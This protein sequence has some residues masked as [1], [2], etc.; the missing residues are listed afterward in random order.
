M[1]RSKGLGRV[2]V[3]G[4]SFAGLLTAA[5]LADHADHV[6]IVDRD[7]IP[8]DP[9]QRPGVPQGRH[10]HVLLAAGRRCVE[11]LLPGIMAEFDELGVPAVGTPGDVVQLHRGRWVRRAGKSV[12]FLTGTRPLL[13][14]VVRRRVLANPRIDTM[15]GIEAVGFMGDRGRVRGLLIRRR[16]DG[17]R[18]EPEEM[19]ADLLV[20]ASGRS[21]H[22]PEWLTAIGAK[23]PAEERIDSGLCYTTR[24]YRG[25]VHPGYKGIYLIPYPESPRG[26]VVMPIEEKGRFLVTL[27][28]VVGDEPP[29]DPRGYELFSK[30]LQH[31]LVHD[32]IMAA[33]PEGPPMGFRGT[34][35]V[36]RRYDRL[37][38]RPRGLLVVGDAACS[39]NPVYG[40]GITVAAGAA[41][42]LRKALAQGVRS[43]KSLQRLVVKSAAQ[44]WT[45]SGGAD[46]KMPRATG[47]AVKDGP[48]DRFADWY[49]ARVEARSTG[50]LAVG[51]P[52]RDVLHLNA[53]AT[54]LFSWPVMR[55]VLFGRIPPTPTEPPL[56]PEPP[57]DTYG[58]PGPA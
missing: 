8:D 13:E 10:I 47:N 11:E 24:M 23:P 48:A 57:E 6:T 40:Q 28:G 52:F 22:T 31:P 37:G 35:N 41:L 49:L 18:S 17:A 43:T 56:Y 45:I 5:V 2:V 58:N 27:S 12:A 7:R 3:V 51:V 26:G 36:R 20:D 16:G 42:A 14:Q 9:E 38:G 55:T 1:G 15:D 19:P 44:A 4:N 53:P 33:E 21:S 54:A 50:N 32:W 30:N 34:A 46:K 29:T 25:P 39:F